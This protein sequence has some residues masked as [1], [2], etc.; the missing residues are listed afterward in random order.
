MILAHLSDLHLGF[1]AFERKDRGRN[2][3]EVDV[4]RAFQTAI[5]K[6]RNIAPQVVLLTGD[7]FDRPEP[8]QGAMVALARGIAT[9]REALPDTKILMVA[10]ARDTPHRPGDPG[11]L[12][13]FD[14]FPGVE[15]ATTRRRVVHLP[16]LDFH[17]VLVPHRSAISDEAEVVT[18]NPDARWNV[19]LAYGDVAESGGSGFTV[20]A[21]EWDYVALG[22]RHSR[23]AVR[24]NVHYS[25]SLERVGP[26]PWEEAVAEKG[27]LSFD[28]LAGVSTFH[29]VAGRPVVSLEPII[30]ESARKT[31]LRER[32]REVL[33]EV[34]GGI[35]GK[36]V[37]L[38]I[39]GLGPGDL[40][41]IQKLLQDYRRQALHLEVS[42]EEAPGPA[43]AR[44]DEEFTSSLSDRL[45]T[46]LG[47]PDMNEDIIRSAVEDALTQASNIVQGS[48][49]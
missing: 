49:G 31:R 12:A 18:P 16:D 40:D 14:A 19:L 7:I 6:M 41:Q 35:G 5:G 33:E 21:D 22:H 45:A 32:V 11:A 9:L 20:R 34:P 4:A 47:T 43:E 28:L 42:I 30:F 15:A 29:P 27:F 17:A 23:V 13:A 3:R 39:Q 26:A 37:R 46:R 48:V 8:T 44:P 2:V 25:G 10:G 24:E 36:I 38:R 1:R